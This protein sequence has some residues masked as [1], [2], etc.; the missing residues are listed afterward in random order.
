MEP[1]FRAADFK[2]GLG[3][4]EDA[5]Q[6]R[7]ERVD[8]I[9]KKRKEDVLERFRK[10]AA[11]VTVTVTVAELLR[12][13]SLKAF[14]EGHYDSLCLLN[15]ICRLGNEQQLNECIPL[16]LGGDGA[17][18]QRLVSYIETPSA[19][20]EQ[21]MDILI[22]LTGAPTRH[23][24]PIAQTVIGC[25]FLQH[26][27]KHVQGN[28]PF[29]KD[30]WGIIANLTCLCSE[31]RDC[32]IETPGI[33][34]EAFFF[35]V[36]RATVPPS[37]MLLVACGII[38]VS[39]DLPPPA[40]LK[41]IWPYLVEQLKGI[42]LDD[43]N[44]SMDY[45]LASL[46]NIAKRC[47]DREL[48][49]TLLLYKNAESVSFMMSLI[50][51]V[52]GPNQLRIC[53]FMVIVSLLPNL[54]FQNIALQGGG[55]PIMTQMVQHK[56][57]R[58]RR[59]ALLWMGNLATDG[60]D[61]ANALY[62]SGALEHIFMIIRGRDRGFIVRNAIYVLLAVCNTCMLSSQ[63]ERS[64]DIMK[65]LMD[66]KGV[67]SITADYVDAVGC[68]QSTIDILRMWRDALLWDLNFVT[69][70]LEKYDGVYKITK[71]IAQ[72]PKESQIY[73]FACE[74]ENMT[75]KHESLEMEL[76]DNSAFTI[77]EM[78]GI[79]DPTVLHGTFNF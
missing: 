49:Q 14:L 22:N 46:A 6:R 65:N 27:I 12:R 76:E 44:G 19:N 21:A 35:Q 15:Q 13:Y 42:P 79:N 58:L 67:I 47:K 69:P 10:P 17:G 33:F 52:D 26:A 37:I 29:L 68:T 16:L 55:I 63:D 75:N 54:M 38:Q 1:N 61:Y 56:N 64:N 7:V 40:F 48:F 57:D 31:A 60:I 62:M 43:K 9:R 72:A 3:T 36:Q 71:F 77:H 24:I 20:T 45:A 30:V 50:P 2:K 73:Q 70:L 23:A 5:L 25:N 34:P 51:R 4:G 39:A 41:L 74:I 59:E 66:F 32:V 53:E 11:T 18:I 78:G 8:G 28:S